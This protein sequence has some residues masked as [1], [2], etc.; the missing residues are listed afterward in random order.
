MNNY[1]FSLH[2]LIFIA[3]LIN[4]RRVIAQAIWEEGD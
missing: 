1:D 2:L 3:N 4:T